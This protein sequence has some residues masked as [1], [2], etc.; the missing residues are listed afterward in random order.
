MVFFAGGRA[1]NEATQTK[2][3]RPG[4]VWALQ[5]YNVLPRAVRKKVQ[6]LYIVHEKK[7][8]RMLGEAFARIVSPK[9]KKKIEHG[10]ASTHASRNS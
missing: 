5:A 6:K 10:K 4:L 7:W 3:G 2:D 8:V 9:S 1:G